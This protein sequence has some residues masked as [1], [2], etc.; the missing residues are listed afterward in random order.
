MKASI[1]AILTF[2]LLTACVVSDKAETT[3]ADS[4]V[5]AAP[6]PAPTTADTGIAPASP[7]AAP[8]TPPPPATSVWTV[9]SGGLGPVRVGMTP[10]EL[11]S[12]FGDSL[13]IPAKL[14]E[15]DYVRPKNNPKG[16]AFMIENGKLSRVEV[17]SSSSIKTVEGAGNGNTEAEIKSLYPGQVTVQPH[18]YTDG[19]YLVVKPNGSPANE[20]IVFETDGSKVLHFRSGRTPAVEYVESCS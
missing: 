17:R 15:C 13:V 4:T 1:F 3:L 20:R 11:K 7:P 12:A 5:A 8:E 2:G 19:H 16:V 6:D 10:A 9:N 18:K 14:A